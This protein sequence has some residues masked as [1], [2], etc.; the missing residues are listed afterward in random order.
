MALNPT[1]VRNIK[2]RL[3]H[4]QTFSTCIFCGEVCPTIEL[5]IEHIIP[6]A[7]GG[8]NRISNL[9]LSCKKCNQDR[10]TLNF[11]EYRLYRRG[12]VDVKPKG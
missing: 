3:S 8:D 2:R 5:T 9:A 10:G 1:R 6:K 11:S 4:N 12:A 7:K